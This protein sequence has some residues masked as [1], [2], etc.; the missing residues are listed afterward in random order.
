MDKDHKKSYSN[1]N[2]HMPPVGEKVVVH[3]QNAIEI[4]APPK[5]LNFQQKE[6]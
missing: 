6:D 5:K 4:E 3:I 2:V 1:D